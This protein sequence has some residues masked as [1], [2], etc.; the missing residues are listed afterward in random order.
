MITE[1]AIQKAMKNLGISRDEALEMLQED[2]EINHGANPHPLTPDQE[3]ASKAARICTG[4][5]RKSNGPRERKPNLDKRAIIE[6]LTEKI[7][8]FA[9]DCGDTEEPQVT[10][11]NP[12]RQIDF[13]IR[14]T[15]YRLI[16]SAP[17]K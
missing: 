10:I 17:R 9:T 11:T 2:E 3:K 8:D 6:Y 5:P 15:R 13:S 4:G 12:E 14:G 7:E 1:T 16:L